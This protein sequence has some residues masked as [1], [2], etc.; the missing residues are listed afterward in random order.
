MVLIGCCA[1][2]TGLLL[3]INDLPSAVTMRQ[4]R[5]WADKFGQKN[6]V[7]FIHVKYSFPGIYEPFSTS[8]LSL[9]YSSSYCKVPQEVILFWGEASGA[10]WERKQC[11]VLMLPVCLFVYR[12]S[13]VSQTCSEYLIKLTFMH[14]ICVWLVTS[15]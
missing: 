12:G 3:F 11:C 8:T 2:K 5:F 15:T 7:P 6:F 13:P 4:R 14:S 10:C 9:P 1:K